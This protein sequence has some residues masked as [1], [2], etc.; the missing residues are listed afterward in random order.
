[1]TSPSQLTQNVYLT[2]EMELPQGSSG[3]RTRLSAVLSLLSLSLSTTSL[4]SSYWF[5]GT[6]KVPKPVCGKGLATECFDVPVPVDG[7][8]P[9]ASSQEVVQYSWEAGDDRFTFLTFRSGMWLSCEEI[10]EEPGERCRSFLELTPPTE[11]GEKGLLEF[12]ALQGPCHSALRFGG[13]RLMEKPFLPHLPLGL[14]AKILWL[15]LGAQITYIGLQFI[16]F[17]LLLTDLLLT[18]NPGRGLKL[19]AFAAISSVL[20]AWPGSPSPAAWHQLSPPS[21]PTPGWCWSSSAG[22]VRASK[23]TQGAYRTTTSVSFS[24]CHVQPTR[25]G[26]CPATTSTPISR[27]TRSLKELT[28]IQRYKTRGFNKGPARS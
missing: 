7:G 26:P 18:G 25:E 11:R 16:S 23:K 19:S 12:A 9:N 14:M 8:I 2:Q 17:L 27:P 24:S 4:L 1:M 21:T 15:S 13:K 28:S 5:V 20:S 3:Q 10:M 6:Q 22:T